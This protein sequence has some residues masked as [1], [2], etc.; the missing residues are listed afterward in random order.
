MNNGNN[1][2]AALADMEPNSG[3]EPLGEEKNKGHDSPCRIHVHSIRRRLA[4]SDGVSGKYAID[5]LI[6]AGILKDDSPKYVKEVS[7]SQ[8]KTKGKE[9]TIITIHAVFNP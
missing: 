3:N 7:F 9:K 8:E 4:D 5:G 6:H 2:T 1:N